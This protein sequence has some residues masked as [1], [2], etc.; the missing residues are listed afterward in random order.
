MADEKKK[1]IAADT[2]AESDATKNNVFKTAWKKVS[3]FSVRVWKKVSAFF[4][5][6]WKKIVKIVKDTVGELK[7][8]VWTPKSEVFNSFKLVIATV[9]GI[10]LIIAVIDVSSSAIIKLIAEAIG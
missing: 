2:T 10:S 3:D 7:K 4:V 1:N 9:V 6:I 8:V 5:R